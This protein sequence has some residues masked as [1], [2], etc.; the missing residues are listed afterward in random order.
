MDEMS[1]DVWADQWV[2]LQAASWAVLLALRQAD[3]MDVT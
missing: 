1:A 2:F 3:G